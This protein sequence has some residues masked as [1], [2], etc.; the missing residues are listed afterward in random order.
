MPVNSLPIFSLLPGELATANKEIA[1]MLDKA[2]ESDTILHDHKKEMLETVASL[3]QRTGKK[4]LSSPLYQADLV[5]DRDFLQMK[6]LVRGLKSH[7]DPEQAN[8]ASALWG[9]IVAH[10]SRINEEPYAIESH[11]LN[12]LLGD[13]KSPVNLAHAAK[14]RLE[15]AITRLDDHQKEF[16]R[17]RQSTI[18]AEALNDLPQLAEF[19]GPMRQQLDEA[20]T[21]LR[22]LERRKPETYK[23]LVS[24]LNTLIDDY[25]ARVRSRATR[26]EN[27]ASQPGEQPNA[28]N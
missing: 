4:G 20:L 10:G 22:S 6:Q 16:E 9:V 18:E 14:C 28:Q 12:A 27:D 2:P 24:E 13:L 8:S 15:P 17:L 21:I 25:V 26:R 23:P 3:E 19:L 7:Y 5:R 1:G 11:K